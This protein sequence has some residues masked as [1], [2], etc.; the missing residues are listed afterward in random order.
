MVEGSP[1]ACVVCGSNRNQ[2]AILVD[3]QG[4]PPGKEGHQIYYYRALFATCSHC[5]SSQL[6]VLEHD[7]FNYDEEWNRY[8]YYIV[9]PADTPR[10]VE[11]LT[12]CHDPPSAGCDCAIHTA[13]R[14]S[15]KNLLAERLSREFEP[16][17]S[18]YN[19]SLHIVK[20]RPM[21]KI[22]TNRIK[23]T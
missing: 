10:L 21:L 16:S 3:E 20:G 8:E 1:R 23:G 5:G 2:L 17:Q 12:A 6:E 19:V 13:L 11:L 14:A 7:C 18:I 22:R 9:S 4:I 15:L